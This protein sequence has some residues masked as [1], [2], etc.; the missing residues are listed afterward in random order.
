MGACQIWEA[1]QGQFTDQ[2]N[3]PYFVCTNK[4]RRCARLCV[5]GCR[6]ARVADPVL[7]LRVSSWCAVQGCD[8]TQP[9]SLTL[10]N[11]TSVPS[12]YTLK[13]SYTAPAPVYNG[14]FRVGALRVTAARRREISCCARARALHS[15][16][17]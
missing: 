15:R 7:A 17:G 4:V 3:T 6:I 11:P 9:I 14:Q 13:F 10:A 5:C 2:G 8:P 16:L 12:A 1:Y